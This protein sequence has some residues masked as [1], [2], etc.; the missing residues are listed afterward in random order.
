MRE[1]LQFE[2]H[3][4]TNSKILAHITNFYIKSP[5][6][7]ENKIPKQGPVWKYAINSS[8]LSGYQSVNQSAS[9][10]WYTP[11]RIGTCDCICS[12]PRRRGRSGTVGHIL[13]NA[14]YKHAGNTFKAAYQAGHNQTVHY[15]L[16]NSAPILGHS[17][18]SSRIIFSDIFKWLQQIKL[19]PHMHMHEP[20]GEYHTNQTIPFAVRAHPQMDEMDLYIVGLSKHRSS[21][22]SSL[23]YRLGMSTILLFP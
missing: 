9:P 18:R 1:V 15:P 20:G 11:D 14:G 2:W 22:T 4:M 17:N 16:R 7:A 3:S 12:L 5:R 10:L 13:L 21:P 19:D 8:C 23:L 6:I